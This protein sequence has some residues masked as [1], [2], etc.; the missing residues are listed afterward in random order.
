MDQWRW[1]R[2]V[3]AYAIVCGNPARVIKMI[4]SQDEQQIH[5]ERVQ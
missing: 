1:S 5:D 3:L 4:F 2:G